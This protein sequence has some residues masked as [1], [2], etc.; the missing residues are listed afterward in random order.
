M[1]EKT[2]TNSSKL[3]LALRCVVWSV[4]GIVAAEFYVHLIIP[5]PLFYSTWFDEG[6]HQPDEQFGFVYTPNFAGSMRHKDRV[7]REPLELD[8][9]GLRLSVST[10]DNKEPTQDVV[11]MGGYSMIFSYGLRTERTVAANIANS[12]K[13]PITVHTLS[14][15]GVPLLY[16]FHKFKRFLEKDVKPKVVVLCLYRT[17]DLDILAA[18]FQQVIPKVN[19]DLFRNHESIVL[20][21]SGLPEKIGHPYFQSYVLAGSCRLSESIYAKANRLKNKI[22][23]LTETQV[24]HDIDINQ[25]LVSE[26]KVD[27]IEPNVQEKTTFLIHLQEYFRQRNAKL[28]IVALPIDTD[29]A[30]SKEIDKLDSAQITLLDLCDSLD[31]TNDKWIAAGHYSQQSAKT[32]GKRIAISI[33]PLL[34]Q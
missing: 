33:Q 1:S 27:V 20:V 28:V 8:Q 11:L 15:P 10:N 2:V 17:D 24:P 5:Y 18:E 3:G 19:K 22:T 7:W 4:V 13:I 29:R 26:K 25:N 30:L 21:R 9:H 32:L 16:D 31:E 34:R 14:Q 12:S 6:I 23:G